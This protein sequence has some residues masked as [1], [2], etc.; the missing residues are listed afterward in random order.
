MRILNKQLRFP[1]VA[2]TSPR[3]LVGEA[4]MEGL[5][6]IVRGAHL[7]SPP[8]LWGRDREGGEKVAQFRRGEKLAL[9]YLPTPHPNLP[10]QGGKGQE[11]WRLSVNFHFGLR[12]DIFTLA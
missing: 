8:P 4:A 10:P 2:W 5:S 1:G 6:S 12:G 3:H 7:G 9:C 11:V